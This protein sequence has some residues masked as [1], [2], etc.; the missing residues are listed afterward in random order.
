MRCNRGFTLAETLIALGVFTFAVLGIVLSLDAVVDVAR[1]TQRESAIRA[2]LQS[3]LAVLS[4]LPIREHRFE[5]PPSVDGVIYIESVLP[6]VLRKSDAT[7][8]SGFYRFSVTAKWL[9]RGVPQEWELS[10]LEFRE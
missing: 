10:H 4:N 8:V 3:R 6:E 2:E 9:D 1:A 7:L 5:S